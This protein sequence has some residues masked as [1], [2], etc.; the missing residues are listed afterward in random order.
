[1]EEV[2]HHPIRPSA[3]FCSTGDFS[4]RGQRAMWKLTRTYVEDGGRF[5]IGGP[6]VSHMRTDAID[7]LL[8][9]LGLPWKMLEY[10]RTTHYR[11]DAHPLLAAPPETAVARALLPESYSMKSILLQ[12][13]ADQ[14]ALYRTTDKS[15]VES[16]AMAL[17]GG[18]MSG[19]KVTVAATQ[20]GTGSI[21]WV[22]DGGQATKNPGRMHLARP[23]SLPVRNPVLS[24]LA[25]TELLFMFVFCSFRRKWTAASVRLQVAGS[26]AQ[27]NFLGGNRVCAE[28]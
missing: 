16:L 17:G 27:E 20:V 19:G 7:E 1:M 18:K 8:A 23:R 13:V 15:Q 25:C 10:M 24:C 9:G 22:G 26:G 2:Y 6:A 21:S 4:K 12:G 11:N 3:I 28:R 5:V 14:D